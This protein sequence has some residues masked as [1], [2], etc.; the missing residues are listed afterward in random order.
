MNNVTLAHIG[1]EL[2]VI[3]GIA[4]YFQR[5]TSALEHQI[6]QLQQENRELVTAIDELGD[7]MQQLAAMVMQGRQQPRQAPAPVP[8]QGRTR[9]D[10]RP[11]PVSQVIDSAQ[12]APPTTKA[13]SDDNDSGNETLD[14][15]ELD[16]ELEQDL[17]E[18]EESRKCD[19]DVCEL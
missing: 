10:R 7:Q 8:R 1:G 14:D 4:F 15:R 3:G 17:Q 19:G 9:K 6:L 11:P 18:L 12:R 16:R 13:F 2:V 5:K